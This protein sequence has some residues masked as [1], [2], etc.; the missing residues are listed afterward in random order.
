MTC[1]GGKAK[2]T[3]ECGVFDESGKMGADKL[4]MIAGNGIR[5]RQDRLKDP[6]AKIVGNWNSA[7][8]EEC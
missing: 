4:T 8:V 1:S 2:D 7:G 6:P 3:P 5:Y